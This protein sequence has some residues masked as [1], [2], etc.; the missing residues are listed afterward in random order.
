MVTAELIVAE[1]WSVDSTYYALND[2]PTLLLGFDLHGQPIDSVAVRELIKQMAASGGNYL[3]LPTRDL[4]TTRVKDYL[5][6]SNE[7]GIL[8]DTVGGKYDFR[9]MGSIA[10]FNA[11][12]LAGQPAVGY[13]QPVQSALNSFRAIRTVERHL[14]FWD[15]RTDDR[16]L[17]TSRPVGSL[18]AVD[19]LQNYLVYVAG[20]GAVQLNLLDSSQIARRVTVVGYLGTQRSEILYPP[21]DRSFTL[22][23]NEER[24][25]WMI[26]EPLAE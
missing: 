3:G 6:L 21:Y 13:R 20:N 8:V 14:N 2:K 1:R 9:S 22:Q 19:S 5:A 26:I 12:V 11:A 24:G 25:G 10:S 23:S 15:L 18:A 16:I 7:L 4:S 17:G